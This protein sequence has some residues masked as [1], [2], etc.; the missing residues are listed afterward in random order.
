M[1]RSPPASLVEGPAY[2][3][4]A[5]GSPAAVVVAGVHHILVP[6]AQWVAVTTPCPKAPALEEVVTAI[7]CILDPDVMS[8]RAGAAVT[9]TP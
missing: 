6:A 5:G 1:A 9:V 4:P 7:R 2:Q 3:A 8:S